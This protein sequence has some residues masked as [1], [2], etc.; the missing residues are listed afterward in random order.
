MLPPGRYDV[1]ASTPGMATKT[2]SGVELFVGGVAVVQLR[3][4]PAALTQTI[5]VRAAHAGG[6]RHPKQRAI[7]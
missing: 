5:T 2:S 6:D 1:S 3:L 7:R 4:A